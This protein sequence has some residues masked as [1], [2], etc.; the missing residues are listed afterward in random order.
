[1]EDKLHGDNLD[2]VVVRDCP[3]CGHR[4]P[5]EPY[6]KSRGGEVHEDVKEIITA[7]LTC[8]A[9]LTLGVVV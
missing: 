6:S 8:G 7:C 4:T 1:M 9:I 3:K 2:G 5:Q